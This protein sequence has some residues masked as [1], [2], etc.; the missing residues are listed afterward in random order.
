MIDNISSATHGEIQMELSRIDYKVRL[1]TPA[2]TDPNARQLMDYHK[3]LL[4]RKYQIEYQYDI[5]LER[6][7]ELQKTLAQLAD[8]NCYDLK[9]SEASRELQVVC[10]ALKKWETPKDEH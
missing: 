2:T 7:A 10:G 8:A 4:D 1:Y 3:Q 9:Y 5:L 6:K